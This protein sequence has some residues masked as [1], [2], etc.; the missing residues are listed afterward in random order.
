MVEIVLDVSER[1]C[2]VREEGSLQASVNIIC[3]T[4]G[5]QFSIGEVIRAE[6]VI[7]AFFDGVG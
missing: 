2:A 1:A 3:S 5:G 7:L 6:D 4:S